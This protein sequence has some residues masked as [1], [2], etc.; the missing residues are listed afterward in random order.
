VLWLGR[1]SFLDKAD[2]LP[3]VQAV[4]RLEP[5][6]GGDRAADA[7]MPHLLVAGSGPAHVGRVLRDY[8]Q[9]LGA[10]ERLTVV[11]PA[12]PE[13]RGELF[14]A[15]DVFCSPAD[16]VQE[17]FGLTPLEAMASGVPQVVSDWSG[18]RDTVVD[19]ETGFLVPTWF[20]HDD[21]EACLGSAL[22]DG[23]DLYD[24]LLLAQSTAVDVDALRAALER[25][26]DEP[27]LCRRMAAASRRRAV[28]RF[29]WPVVVERC[30]ALWDELSAV[31]ART[32]SD[33]DLSR[34]YAAPALRASFGHFATAVLRPEAEL[35]LTSAGARVLAGEEPLPAYAGAMGAIRPELAV[36][37]LTAAAGVLPASL[38]Q[39]A[40]QVDTA[41]A[42]AAR[43]DGAPPAGERH[44]M[45]LLKHG[46]IRA[47]AVP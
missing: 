1:L 3:L 30:E 28:E 26:L 8:A 24:H 12:P 13:R 42:A 18:Y 27:E 10:A 15:A 36:S 16:S 39:L 41:D 46:L 6:A 31:A 38:A 29:G 43:S 37:A 40:A 45:W 25:L 34:D 20:P 4:A 21:A 14:A 5:R 32:G 35:E 19:G 47:A 9:R 11:E 23:L 22:Y 33:V 17:T 2:L 44:V 7:R